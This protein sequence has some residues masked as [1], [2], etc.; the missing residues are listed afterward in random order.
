MSDLKESL[1]AIAAARGWDKDMATKVIYGAVAKRTVKIDRRGGG[2][3]KV[4][5]SI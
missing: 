5:F 1:G 2:G 4:L 3:G